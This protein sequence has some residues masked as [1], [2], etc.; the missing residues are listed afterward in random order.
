MPAVVI[1]LTMFILGSPCLVLVGLGLLQELPSLCLLK[2]LF[3]NRSI[4]SGVCTA[5][6]NQMERTKS[7]DR[8]GAYGSTVARE[9]L[10]DAVNAQ[11]D[12]LIERQILHAFGSQPLDVFG[13][14][15]MNA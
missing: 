13:R 9:Y 3:N 8:L 5:A 2:R 4:A 1:S 6:S 7:R 10:V 12:E 14:D 11:A 15:P